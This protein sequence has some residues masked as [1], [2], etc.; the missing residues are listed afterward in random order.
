MGSYEEPMS[1]D[2]IRWSQ[3]YSADFTPSVQ[4]SVRQN[5]RILAQF[6]WQFLLAARSSSALKTA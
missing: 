6:F 3:E 1:S 2:P 4:L 5:P